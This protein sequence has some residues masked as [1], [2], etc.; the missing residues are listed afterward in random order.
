M[1]T[2][3]TT[4]PSPLTPAELASYPRLRRTPMQQ[5]AAT[6]IQAILDAAAGILTESGP[7]RLTTTTVAAAAGVS[8]GTVYQFFADAESILAALIHRDPTPYLEALTAAG[9]TEDAARRLLAADPAAAIRAS[10]ALTVGS[11]R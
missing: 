2:T 8:V 1:T 11:V 7:R 10:A 6:R 4:Q 3:T 5:R 9:L